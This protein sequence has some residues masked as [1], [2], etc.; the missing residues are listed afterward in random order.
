MSESDQRYHRQIMDSQALH[1][2]HRLHNPEIHP[3]TDYFARN[4]KRVFPQIPTDHPPVTMT[5]GL[6]VD[7]L[8]RKR[9][10]NFWFRYPDFIAHDSEKQA[11][12]L[13]GIVRLTEYATNR[14]TCYYIENSLPKAIGK[15]AAAFGRILDKTLAG[16]PFAVDAYRAMGKVARAAKKNNQDPNVFNKALFT[17]LFSHDFN[18]LDRLIALTPELRARNID[19]LA[20]EVG[21]E[22]LTAK[23]IRKIKNRYEISLPPFAERFVA[24]SKVVDDKFK[25]CLFSLGGAGMFTQ[26]G[27]VELLP[28]L[29]LITNSYSLNLFIRAIQ[30]SRPDI[31]AGAGAAL[32]VMNYV[33]YYT[34]VHELIHAY[35]ASGRYSGLASA[36]LH[37]L[38]ERNKL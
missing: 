15:P 10:Y 38:Q 14:A 12:W 25:K 28:N 21:K 4:M 26:P 13:N 29:A 37:S 5:V 8:V 3:L 22:K 19:E 6:V 9:P 11:R 33:A 30:A 16:A 1:R 36:S 27:I 20:I 18:D 32:T 7:G 2:S 31:A 23:L 34:V 24:L 35:S 17:A